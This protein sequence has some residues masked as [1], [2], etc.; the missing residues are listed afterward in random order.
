MCGWILKRLTA[1]LPTQ[2]PETLLE[3]IIKASS[4]EGDLVLD[5]FVGSGTTAAVAEKLGR[6]WIDM[7][8]RHIHYPQAA[9]GHSRS[10]AVLQ[11]VH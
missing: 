10:Q 1:K 11:R 4:N 9:V 7:G 5:C 2:K 3:R 6:R 8:R